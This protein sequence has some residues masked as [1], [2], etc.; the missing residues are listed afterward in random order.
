MPWRG[1]EPRRLS[2]L[3]PQDSVSTSFTTRARER[4]KIASAKAAV[5]P[6]DRGVSCY[7]PTSKSDGSGQPPE[8]WN[9]LPEIGTPL[10]RIV[11][12]TSLAMMTKASA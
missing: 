5:N 6:L 7:R 9:G 10:T 2:A 1:F 11:T 3:P 8:G 12:V 4:R